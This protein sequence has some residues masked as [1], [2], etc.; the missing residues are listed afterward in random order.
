VRTNYLSGGEVID[1]GAIVS[2]DVNKDGVP[3]YGLGETVFGVIE[4]NDRTGL[5]RCQKC[6][7]QV[8]AALFSVHALMITH[9]SR[10]AG[11]MQE[12]VEGHDGCKKG[13]H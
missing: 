1:S 10:L 8:A 11:E 13:S 5:G 7:V 2:Y 6:G 4:L 12:K 3:A 9:S